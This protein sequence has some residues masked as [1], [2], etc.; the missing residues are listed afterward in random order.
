M[1][2]IIAVLN[3]KGGV[4]K[5][6][7]TVN[8]GA[9]LALLGKKVLLIDADPQANLT[10]SL[11]FMQM[12]ADG[13]ITLSAAMEKPKQVKLPIY[14]YKEGVDV[15]PSSIDLAGTELMLLGVTAKEQIL[16]WLLKPVKDNYDFILIDCPPSLNMLP[17]N[18]LTAA[19]SIIIPIEAEY[20]ALHGMQSLLSV[21]EVVKERLND[22]LEVGGYLLTKYDG[23][24]ILNQ[25][26]AE[27]LRSEYGDLVFKTV[28]RAN[29]ALPESTSQ[30]QDIFTYN[31]NCNGAMDYMELAKEFLN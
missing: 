29:V 19:D 10:S 17:Q 15:V 26:I 3:H 7:T 6:T 25:T 27:N 30:G 2:R 28:I 22:R 11:G 14:F 5:T 4:A 21:V 18:A 31:S 23:R 12:V 13:C 1:G 24:K 20:L 9:A 8:L 16:S